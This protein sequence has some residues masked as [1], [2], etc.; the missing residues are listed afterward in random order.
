MRKT[1]IPLSW[2]EW[3]FCLLK[4][5]PKPRCTQNVFCQRSPSGCGCAI[6]G[7]ALSYRRPL[8]PKQIFLAFPWKTNYNCP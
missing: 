4:R 1:S 6:L 5:C 7:I 2:I 8:W 3:F